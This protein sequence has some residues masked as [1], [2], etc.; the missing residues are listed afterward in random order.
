MPKISYKQ[1]FL[2]LYIAIIVTWTDISGCSYCATQKRSQ[3]V[4]I[5]ESPNSPAKMFHFERLA[6]YPNFLVERIFV[7]KKSSHRVL[8]HVLHL[9]GMMQMHDYIVLSSHTSPIPADNIHARMHKHPH[10]KK[11]KRTIQNNKE[12]RK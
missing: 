12:S 1:I 6:W 9:L 7:L 8:H 11:K 4:Q 5:D 2:S 3:I 10:L